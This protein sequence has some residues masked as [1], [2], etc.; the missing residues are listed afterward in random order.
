MPVVP[1]TKGASSLAAL[2]P[3]Q[4]PP[5][6]TTIPSPNNLLILPQGYPVN[7]GQRL[8]SPS[9]PR[10]ALFEIPST[11]CSLGIR[12]WTHLLFYSL[13]LTTYGCFPLL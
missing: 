5:W 7:I 4:P 1:A 13:Y 11:Y 10:H 6:T 12:H 2:Q 8:L 3:I 9:Q